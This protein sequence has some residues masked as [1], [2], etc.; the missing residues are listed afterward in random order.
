MI[1]HALAA[2]ANNWHVFPVM[3]GTKRP[4][5]PDNLNKSTTDVFQ[6]V[7]WWQSCPDANI[8]I[9]TGPS[10]LVVIDIDVRKAP[11]D[12]DAEL[13][14]YEAWDWILDQ[15]G[16]TT[17]RTYEV[18]T[19]SGGYHLYFKAN[20]ALPVKTLAGALAPG[21]DTR[22]VNGSIVAAGSVTE[23][24]KYRVVN[25]A[26]PIAVPHWLRSALSRAGL[27]A[28]R[29]ET[30][31]RDEAVALRRDRAG[32]VADGTAYA[33]RGLELEC[34]E[35]RNAAPSTANHTLNE[36][37]FALR[38]KHIEQGNLN[39][40]DAHEALMRAALDRNIPHKEAENT[41][42]SAFKGLM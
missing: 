34:E 7:N 21:I 4:L 15:A 27:T 14:G 28:G 32:G 20:D 24:G 13:H 11:F 8:G 29:I 41:L 1:D 22:A 9:A 30:K 31:A 19:P 18:E 38:V 5:I 2:A 36:R 10:N 37:A 40:F 26:P 39:V 3:P 25:A 42:G 16:I 17:V 33:R 23:V 12:V 35:I 6:I